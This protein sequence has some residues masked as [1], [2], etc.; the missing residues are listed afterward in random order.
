MAG[1]GVHTSRE[2]RW[3]AVVS[4]RSGETED[5]TIA[6][7]VVAAETA[8]IKTGAPSPTERVG[9]PK[10]LLRVEEE[11]RAAARFAGQAG[12]GQSAEST[13]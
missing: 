2:N 9:K 11:I 3:A 12:L 1:R 6:D 8:Q 13:A 4:H 7:V 5:T 10:R